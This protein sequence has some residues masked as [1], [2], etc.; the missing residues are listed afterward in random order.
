MIDA[1]EGVHPLPERERE[2]IWPMLTE[3]I[4]E[5]GDHYI[6]AGEVAEYVAYVRSGMLRYF[7]T[8]A[9]G[10]EYTRYFCSGGSFVSVSSS[11]GSPSPFTVRALERTE[12]AL[13]RY[14]DLL[15]LIDTHP[16][17]GRIVFH[18]NEAALGLAAERER[19]L[20]MDDAT[21]RYLNLLRDF[22]G[23][24]SKVRQYDIASY[25]G[26]TPVALSRIRGRTINLG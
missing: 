13:L 20:I 8:D 24:E 16:V 1:L 26:V 18:L 12:A 21:T 9:E 17:W 11:K 3:R 10:H 6:R 22:P 23:I 25:L 2:R 14:R 15:Q 5:P 7:Y 4:L 19:S